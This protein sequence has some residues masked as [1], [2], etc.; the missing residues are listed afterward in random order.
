MLVREHPARERLGGQLMIALYRSGRQ[1]DALE[2]YR[3]MQRTLA[4]ELGLQPGPELQ[5]LQRAVLEQDP[6]IAAP[7]NGLAAGLRQRRRGG[8]LIA[9]GGTALLAAAAAAI[10]IA[11]GGGDA[12]IDVRQRELPGCDRPG[13]ELSRRHPADRRSAG[14]RR[15]GRRT[16][17]GRQP[18]R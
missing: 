6:A 4:D 5:D 13:L 7:T 15:R 8:A 17:L 14:R 9:I 18:R 1:S 12:G 2:S 3:H 10:V 16:C 11:A